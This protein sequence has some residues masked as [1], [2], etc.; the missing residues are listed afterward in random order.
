MLNMETTEAKKKVGFQGATILASKRSICTSHTRHVS[1]ES[2][3][4]TTV[5]SPAWITQPG[6]AR[7]LHSLFHPFHSTPFND[8]WQYEAE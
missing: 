1:V 2:I 8:L 3:Y 5:M 4:N 7:L 6:E